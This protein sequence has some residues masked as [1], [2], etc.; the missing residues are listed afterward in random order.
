MV[1]WMAAILTRCSSIAAANSAGVPLRAAEPAV[2]TRLR[3]AGSEVIACTSVD[4]AILD[5]R[6]HAAPPIDADSTLE[7]Q[8]GIARF[9]RGR[10]VGRLRRA[11]ACWSRTGAWR[12][13]R[14]GA[15]PA[16][17]RRWPPHAG[18]PGQ[19]LRGRREIAIGN[20]HHVDARC[21]SEAP[22]HVVRAS[23]GVAAQLSLPGC[24]LAALT[25]SASVFGLQRGAGRTPRKLSDTGAI[26]TRSPDRVVGQLL[27]HAAD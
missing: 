16:A 18:G 20:L 11:L 8:V 12:Y 26:G 22:A 21:C 3:N 14:D 1:L 2:G 25:R 9:A 7:G 13:R 6:R 17:A 5:F 24:S 10:H 27:V 19:V 4:D 15:A 23:P